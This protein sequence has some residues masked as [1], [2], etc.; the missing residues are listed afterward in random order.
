LLAL[1]QLLIQACTTQWLVDNLFNTHWL[2]LY[3][4]K[5]FGSD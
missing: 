1:H 4:I 5:C 3:Y 2:I